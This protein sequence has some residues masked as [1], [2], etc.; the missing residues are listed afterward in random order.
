MVWLSTRRWQNS[1]LR[2]VTALF[3]AGCGDS[4]GG[5]DFYVTINSDFVTDQA[6]VSLGGTTSLPQ[7]SERL[8]GTAAMPIVTCSLGTYSLT[9]HNQDSNA[10]GDAFEL[11][12]CGENFARWSALRVPV[13]AGTN[14]IT[15]TFRDSSR[16][17][18]AVVTVTRR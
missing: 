8:G 2:A 3:L 17:A 9:W 4:G 14:R 7:G 13:D 18:E 10:T 11:W 6:Q 16:T 15:V 1:L 12:N 5:E